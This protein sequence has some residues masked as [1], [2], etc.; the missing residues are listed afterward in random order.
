MPKITKVAAFL[1]EMNAVLPWNDLLSVIQPHYK[2][3]EGGRP[4]QPLERMLRI[5]F[6]QIWYELSDPAVEDE[7]YEKYSFQQFVGLDGFTM[8]PPDETTILNFRHLLEEHDLAMGLL[9]TV[10]AYLATKGLVCKQG[11]ITDATLLHAPSSTKNASKKRD[12]EMSSTQKNKQWFF[13][14]KLHIG[15]QAKGKPIIHTAILTTAKAHDYPVSE[16][17]LHGE[18]QAVFG[19]GAYGSQSDKQMARG[20]GVY[21]GVI[22]KRK[23]GQK[24]LSSSQKKRNRRHSGLRAKVEHPFRIIKVQWRGAKM[25]YRGLKK[26]A[27]RFVSACALANLYMC[28]KLLAA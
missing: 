7:L 10:N 5:Y 13:G 21:Y 3:G 1:A 23:R 16:K 25:R 18:E 4:A 2:T 15:V 12:P 20:L 24:R 6:L 8:R 9:T 27:C 28:R 22:E 19:D 26:N 11:T 17:L 14:A